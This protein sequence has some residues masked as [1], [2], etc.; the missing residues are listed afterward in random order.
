MI[1]RQDAKSAKENRSDIKPRDFSPA[2]AFL[3]VLGVLAAKT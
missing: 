2:C 1:R 3:G